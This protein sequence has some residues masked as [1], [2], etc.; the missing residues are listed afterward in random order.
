MT[1]CRC[2]LRESSVGSSLE[3][4]LGNARSLA[5]HN[6]HVADAELA[7]QMTSTYVKDLWYT[8]HVNTVQITINRPMAEPR[9]EDIPVSGKDYKFLENNNKLYLTHFDI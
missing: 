1:T 4:I 5:S 8:K 6:A 3:T 9:G 7:A 2:R